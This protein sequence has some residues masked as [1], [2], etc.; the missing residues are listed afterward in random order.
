MMQR[1][2]HDFYR[3]RLVLITGGLGFLG[4]NLA[5]ALQ[6]AGARLTV[7]DAMIPGCGANASNLEG[8]GIRLERCDIGDGSA[9][10]R[11]LP[12]A[13]VIFNLAGEISHTRSVTHPERDLDLNARS[14]LRFLMS[15]RRLAPRAR[16]IFASSRQIYGVPKYLP[17]D[18]NHPVC[19][20]DFNGIHKWAAETYHRILS[21][22]DDMETVCLRLTNVYG[23]RQALNLPWQGFIGTFLSR[24]LRGL[25][26]EVYGS[27]SQ[28][29]D[30][31]YA[32]DAVE[33]FLGCG[34]CPLEA[35][36]RHA[37]FN[38]GGP[39]PLPL[40]GIA[41]AVVEAARPTRSEV[42]YIEFPP[43][44]RKIDIGDYYADNRAIGRWCG[45][46]PRVAFAEG[47]RET[48]EFYRQRAG[49]YPL[50]PADPIL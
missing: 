7:V 25:P 39:K 46:S 48:V 30:M 26:V 50:E 34:E 49:E 8:A 27:G 42:T 29:R 35:G 4:S 19:P 36:G 9:M 12:G 3:D 17:V 41:E 21:V 24:A 11:L 10:E 43:S 20:T 6:R 37:V 16:V 47:I 28:L 1:E 45:W 44:R 2:A 15:C 38:I 33:A 22:T 31:L 5:L 23:P 13:E 40:A 32:G 14:Q 18:E